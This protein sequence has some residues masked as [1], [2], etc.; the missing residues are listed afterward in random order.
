M[1]TREPSPR[2][3]PRGAPPAVGWEKGLDYLR[4]DGSTDADERD[5]MVTHFAAPAY[6]LF[7]ISTKVA[8]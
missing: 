6:K 1:L 5:R 4:L 2:P 3:A 8:M 7:L